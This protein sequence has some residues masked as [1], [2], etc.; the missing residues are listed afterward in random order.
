VIRYGTRA[1]WSGV[2]G[3]IQ[4]EKVKRME[5]VHVSSERVCHE[6]REHNK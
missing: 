2:N 4:F 5:V 3:G 1:G 6:C